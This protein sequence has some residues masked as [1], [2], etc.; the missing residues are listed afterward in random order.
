MK[1]KAKAKITEEAMAINHPFG[2]FIEEYLTGRIDKSEEVAK[3]IFESDK[4]LDDFCKK[5]AEEARKEA[6]KLGTGAQCAGKPDKE[7]F[8]DA[9]KYYGIDNLTAPA[10]E[11]INILDLI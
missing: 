11:V 9:E 8:A 4:T 3:I 10:S 1:E 7:Y 2:F 6:K 5:A